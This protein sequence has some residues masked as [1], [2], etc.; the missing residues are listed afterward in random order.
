M[1][2]KTIQN[3]TAVASATL[4]HSPGSHTS[5]G[6]ATAVVPAVHSKKG[7]LGLWMLTALVAGN[8]IGSG[9]F[10]LPAALAHYGS[11][12]I[13]A[14]VLTATGAIF[15]ALVFCRLSELIPKTGGP[16]T[17]C[18]I[19]FGD[20]V[21]FQVAYNY[22]VALC[23]GNAAIVVALVAYLGVFWPEVKD[24]L[25]L[26]FFVKAG[27]VWL[28]TLVNILGVRKAGVLQ[29]VTT[30]LKILPLLLIGIL[31]LFFIQPENLAHF[32]LTGQPTLPALTGAATLTLWAFIGLESAT[33]PA[34]EASNPKDVS[35]ATILGTVIAALVY[36]LSTVAVMGIIS[37]ANL[38]TSTAPFAD[39]AN[40]MLGGW[41]GWL[42][43]IGAIV[44]CFGALNGWTLLQG[45]IP[46]AAAR[47]GMFPAIF[48][49]KSRY[50]TPV[51]GLVLSSVLITALLALT[52]NQTL[53]H[54]FTFII[55]LATLAALIPYFFTAMAELMIFI[56]YREHFKGQRLIKSVIIAVL[57]G[58]YSFWAI[59]G[60]G[61]EKVFYGMLLFFSG[62]PIY[63]WMRWKTQ[64]IEGL[65]D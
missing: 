45:Q 25:Y 37:P 46:Y 14:W 60:S 28:L 6:L 15:L 40:V 11:I 65:D 63:I 24:D 48:A 29:L 9:I 33:V 57:A 58:T 4:G 2:L 8:M 20:F 21:G 32:N 12:S 64:V 34:E 30:I 17:Y 7:K 10:M 53:V 56:K 59:A 61:H 41:G 13:L 5:G 19:A 27:I 23:V 49:R 43:A 42:I 16:Y 52:L 31:G 39:A 26:S 44:S 51:F 50:G 3:T 62:I 18:R 47:D 54:Q 35:R 22:W 1:T 36:I 55:L 38:A